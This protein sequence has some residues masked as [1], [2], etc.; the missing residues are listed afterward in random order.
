MS[1]A[2]ATPSVSDP[3][4][5]APAGRWRP[6]M[7]L[8]SATDREAAARALPHMRT[9][10]VLGAVTRRVVPTL[11]EATV[12]PAALVYTFL[13]L[14]NLMAAMAA[15]LSWAFGVLAWRRLT[16]RAIPGVLVL[17]AVGLTVRTVVAMASGSARL[18][19]LQPI[20]TTLVLAALFLASLCTDRPIIA[21]LA[22]DF[23]PLAP[24]VARRPA[25]T[26]LFRDLTLVWAAVHIT[27]AATTFALLA[28]LPTAT[29]VAVKTLASV[30]IC[31]CAVV[32]TVARSVRIARREQLAF[33]LGARPPVQADAAE[34]A[35]TSA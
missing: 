12:I 13:A 10:P 29:Y 16:Q 3:V 24:D 1:V 20:A 6:T 9:L 35:P 18:Y 8:V 19:F 11:I 7:M 17:A 2:L 14:G 21:R 26:K 22:G 33:A 25:I 4:E 31:A 23:C 27:T 32:V 34:P 5:A 15:A 28:T 30:S